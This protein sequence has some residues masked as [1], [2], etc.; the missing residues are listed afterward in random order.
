[1]K[2]KRNRYWTVLKWLGGTAIIALII[3]LLAPTLI[4]SLDENIRDQVL[5]QSIPFFS[6]FVAI[7]MTYILIIALLMIRFT[8]KIP[9]RIYRPVD[10][11]ITIGIIGGIVCLFQPFIFVAFRY[12]FQLLLLS[13]LL[14]IV[15]SHIVPRKAKQD[16]LMPAVSRMATMVGVIAAV[17]VYALF[18][19]TMVEANKLVE[20]YG[21]RQR[22]WNSYDDTQKAQI[23]EQVQAEYSTQ[24][25]PFLVV[26]CLWPAAFVFFGVR[27]VIDGW[28]FRKV[29]AAPERALNEG[30][31]FSGVG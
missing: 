3:S 27:G 23:A 12:G 2:P 29:N 30:V 21:I 4:Q 5:I 10:M 7:L 26:F 17:A 13:T 6:A 1:M 31:A 9:H 11:L 8:G 16:T 25:V 24:I 19:L 18:F 14:F 15:W 20:P 28:Q 22:L